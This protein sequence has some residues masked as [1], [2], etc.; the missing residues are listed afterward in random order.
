MKCSRVAAATLLAVALAGCSSA[1]VGTQSYG[2][3]SPPVATQSSEAARPAPHELPTDPAASIWG[4]WNLSEQ[5]ASLLV[6]HFPGADEDATED[7]LQAIKPA[8]VILMG[9]SIP[10]PESA[11]AEQTRHWQTM[12][13]EDG[14]PPL[15]ISIDQEGGLVRRLQED[16]A[17]GAP[18]VRAQGPD[19]VREAFAQ[20]GTYLASLGVNVNF[21]IIADTT[22]DPDSFIFPRV[23]GTDPQSAAASVAAAV[24]GEAA[25]S[26]GRVA[27]TLKHFPG[28]GMTSQDS[29]Q[30]IAE[31]AN[32]TLEQ[33]GDSAA[34]PFE[35]GVD[36]GAG[37]VMMSHVDCPRVAPGPASMESR[38]YQVLRDDLGFDGVIVTDDLSMLTATG[39]ADFADPVANA[40][41][42]I[43]AGTTLVL[44]IGGESPEQA[45]EY[46]KDLVDGISDA[47]ERGVISRE[48]FD[49]AGLRALRFRLSLR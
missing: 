11:L 4:H 30:V 6:L 12:A 25:G 24:E 8:G 37:L 47:V 22:D 45:L 43:N 21:G 14:Q 16:P 17:P 29:H 49:D 3:S 48:V 39:E 42:A 18:E 46:A 9:D 31:C 19:T 41:S 15:I 32:I 2:G 35:A 13:H 40:V 28:H 1:G 36:A 23:L 27:S 10:D 5:V 44:S 33:W 20:R 7:F 38:W 26:D 34:I